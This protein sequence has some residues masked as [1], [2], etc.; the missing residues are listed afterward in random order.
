M[1][2]HHKWFPDK[3]EAPVKTDTKTAGKDNILPFDI[4]KSVV[5]R[6]DCPLKD[7]FPTKDQVIAFCRNAPNGLVKNLTGFSRV[8][9]QGMTKSDQMN[10]SRYSDWQS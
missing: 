8:I 9:F 2:L 7:L 10:Q 3:K 5:N 1:Q 4:P 6:P